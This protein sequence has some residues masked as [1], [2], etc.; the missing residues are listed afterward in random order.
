MLDNLQIL[1]L[2]QLWCKRTAPPLNDIGKRK[3]CLTIPV[4]LLAT[5]TQDD[6]AILTSRKDMGGFAGTMRR[7]EVHVFDWLLWT[8]YQQDLTL[9]SQRR[10]TL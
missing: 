2:P 4:V 6:S 7:A 10:E 9:Y 5:P 1:R 3:I 8:F